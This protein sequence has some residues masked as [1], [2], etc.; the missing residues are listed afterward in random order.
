L[1]WLW[2]TNL[3]LL[4]GAELNA[5]LERSRAIAAGLPGDEEPYVEL[6]DAR[7]IKS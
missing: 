2:V 6:R 1:V 5:E 4:I 7:A 3:A